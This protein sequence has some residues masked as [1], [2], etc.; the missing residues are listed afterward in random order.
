MLASS[1]FL[2]TALSHSVPASIE[3]VVPASDDP[4]SFQQAQVGLELLPVLLVLVGIRVEQGNRGRGVF[5]G[6]HGKRLSRL[7]RMRSG[8]GPVGRPSPV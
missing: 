3:R 7:V 4:L 1:R 2:S 8:V 5:R 6:G